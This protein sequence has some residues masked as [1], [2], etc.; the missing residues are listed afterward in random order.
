MIKP[1][2]ESE[3]KPN[4]THFPPPNKNEPQKFEQ[5]EVDCD[6]VNIQQ[7]NISKENQNRSVKK[8]EKI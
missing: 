2:P 1:G 3:Q 7:V 4:V 5:N 8:Y 6:N